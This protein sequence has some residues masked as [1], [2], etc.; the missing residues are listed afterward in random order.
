[1]SGVLV[2]SQRAARVALTRARTGCVRTEKID[3]RGIARGHVRVPDH[4]HLYVFE[5]VDATTTST[6]TS[7]D[8][9]D[10]ASSGRDRGRGRDL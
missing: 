8:A 5:Y 3:E 7:D 2:S 6:S 9:T 1:M 10:L 4:D